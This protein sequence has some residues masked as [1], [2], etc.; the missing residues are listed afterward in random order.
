MAADNALACCNDTCC[1]PADLT[2]EE[3]SL[4]KGLYAQDEVA[5]LPQ[6]ALDAAAGCGNPMAIAELR[7]GETVLDL[8]SGGGIDCFLAGKQVGPEG[9]VIGVD[10]TPDMIALARK[11]AGE[12]GAAN[13]EFR[14]GEIEV[15]PV[16][17]ASVDAVI[18]NC[19]INL[20][21]DKPAVLAEVARVLKP[22]GRFRVSDI[23]WTQGRPADAETAED[24]AGCIAG[25]LELDE[26]IA[27][28]TEAGLVN[29][30]ADAVRYLDESRGLASA[31]VSAEKPA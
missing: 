15:L 31:L 5:G 10:M 11:N 14:L 27:G 30:R 6:A 20:S 2:D 13:V 17:D 12:V 25:A 8:G 16:R 22:G 19:V 26:F 29:A 7:P 23:V 4:V 18:S 1:V 24:W 28:L 3:R 9:K 21:T